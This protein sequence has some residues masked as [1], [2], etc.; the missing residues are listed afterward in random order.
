MVIEVNYVCYMPNTTYRISLL[1][2]GLSL[3]IADNGGKMENIPSKSPY[4]MT[5]LKILFIKA[6]PSPSGTTA[7]MQEV[8]RSGIKSREG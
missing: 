8:G 2:I 3:Q 7:W 6:V 5:N 1:I 4:F